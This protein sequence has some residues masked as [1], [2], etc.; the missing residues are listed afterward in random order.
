M[1]L[2]RGKKKPKIFVDPMF[3]SS[4]VLLS[5]PGYSRTRMT[6]KLI[7]MMDKGYD[8]RHTIKA[9]ID[10]SYSVNLEEF[11]GSLENAGYLESVGS[12]IVLTENGTNLLEDNIIKNYRLDPNTTRMFAKDFGFSIDSTLGRFID[13]HIED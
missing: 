1:S 12:G 11:V 2:F 6:E 13:R 7:E 3:A 10:G 5:Y 9:S 4:A 8:I